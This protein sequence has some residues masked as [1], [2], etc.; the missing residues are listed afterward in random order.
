MPLCIHSLCCRACQILHIF[1]RQTTPA[2]QQRPSLCKPKKQNSPCKTKE[3]YPM[4]MFCQIKFT[5]TC[6][7]N[8]NELNIC[9]HRVTLP[10]V[11]LLIVARYAD[12]GETGLLLHLRGC[13]HSKVQG[14]KSECVLQ[15][16]TSSIQ[17]AHPHSES[18][19]HKRREN[20]SLL[21]RKWNCCL[22]AL[23]T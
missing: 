21:A 14:G 19:L 16:R 10:L 15:D 11:P 18:R 22:S 2:V 13:W 7:W 23:H 4:L 9:T 20:R 6:T 1:W 5:Q 8:M 12:I 3:Y 17:L